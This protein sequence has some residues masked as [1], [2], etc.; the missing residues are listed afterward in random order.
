MSMKLSKSLS[1]ILAITFIIS[2]SVI[3]LPSAFANPDVN[4]LQ[5]CLKEEDSSLDVLVLMDSSR[6]LRN[7]DPK[8]DKDGWTNKDGASDPKGIRGP[9]LKS[10]LKLLLDLAK[11]SDHSFRINLKN[12]GDNSGSLGELKS[13][14]M[15]WTE[16]TTSNQNSVL[17]DFVNRAL[18]DDS[19]G[20]EW[21]AGLN[22]ARDS[23]N[24]RFNTAA[25]DEQK[26]C[27]VMIWITDGAPSDRNP[28][29]G[30][31]VCQSNFQ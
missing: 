18:Y 1:S 7:A 15:D 17:D 19:H 16:V 5:T 13:N 24:K 28:S 25:N 2:L 8:V 23:F 31:D 12:F 10:S 30:V 6:S 9:L 26:S 3:E 20:T 14:W 27:P 4:Y 29:A 21:G 11:E 22:T